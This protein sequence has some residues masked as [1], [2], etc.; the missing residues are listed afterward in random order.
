MGI[1]ERYFLKK[2]AWALL[3]YRTLGQEEV[4]EP[5]GIDVI[6]WEFPVT[7]SLNQNKD[8]LARAYRKRINQYKFYSLTRR[9]K[10]EANFLLSRETISGINAEEHGRRLK[11]F[12]PQ[13]SKRVKRTAA[14]AK[15][16]IRIQSISGPRGKQ[17]RAKRISNVCYRAI[18][19]EWKIHSV[20]LNL[21]DRTKRLVS[22]YE[23][24][25][26][27]YGWPVLSESEIVKIAN[28]AGRTK[29]QKIFR[30]VR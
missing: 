6:C 19:Q 4:G 29:A 7:L 23:E 12:I 30:K 25:Y 14:Q 3:S 20:A 1:K 15:E 5:D 2:D 26:D 24:R 16:E 11:A 18:K 27:F 10:T 17:S 22:W 28:S 13:V 9:L 21:E 8:L